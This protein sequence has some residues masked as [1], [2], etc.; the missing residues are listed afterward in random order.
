M[1]AEDGAG[2]DSSERSR[3]GTSGTV[4]SAPAR[5]DLDAAAPATDAER[6]GPAPAAGAAPRER[7]TALAD[8][9]DEPRGLDALDGEE[10]APEALAV[11]PEEGPGDLEEEVSSATATPAA[12]GPTRNRPSAN[13][14]APTRGTLLRDDISGFFR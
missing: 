9:R 11:D 1:T 6:V 14:A 13:A 7:P 2:P 12:C 4:A 10:S 3:T 5:A 8:E